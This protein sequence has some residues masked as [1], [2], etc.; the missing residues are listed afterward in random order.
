M[1]T[2]QSIP[3]IIDLDAIYRADQDNNEVLATMICY[4]KQN[5]QLQIT[6]PYIAQQ[7]TVIQ[8]IIKVSVN[9]K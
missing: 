9:V 7:A 1:S 2:T 6:L 4:N 5:K 8:G 3:G